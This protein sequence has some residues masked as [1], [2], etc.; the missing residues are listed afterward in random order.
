MSG[1]SLGLI[2]FATVCAGS[3]LQRTSG[4]GLG[5][6]ASSVLS[7]VLGPVDGIFVVNLLATINAALIT[8]LV[9]RRIEWRRFALIGS[10]MIL[11]AIP[12]AILVH[13]FSTGVLQIIIGAGLL[14][15]LGLVTFGARLFPPVTGKLPA[16]GAGITGGLMNTVAG[17]AGPAVTVYAQLARWDHVR[18][19]ATLQPIFVV[20][21]A[22]SFG[23]K[24]A[25]LGPSPVLGIA[26]IVWLSGLV[27][28]LVGIGLGTKLER[29]VP[30]AKA[31]R[32]ALT[33]AIL[34]GASAL[35][36]GVIAV[37]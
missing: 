29:Y 27:S 33:V 26:P 28:M 24:I 8:T 15:A 17:V 16:I 13:Y 20:A 6:I 18:F 12:G 3:F 22:L 11:G 5:L 35:V 23:T 31:R 19:A 25:V 1:I 34:G 2:V 32:V 10:V 4:M 37:I 36:R 14:L 9:W 30:K 7:I 21:G